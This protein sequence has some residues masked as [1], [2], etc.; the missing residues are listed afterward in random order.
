VLQDQGVSTLR[1]ALRNVA[2]IS[3]AAGEG[4]AQGDNLT[5]RG[6]SARNDIFLDGMR[7]F[8]SYYRDSFDMEE[9]EVLQG[10][11]SMT[12]GRG[13][14]GGVVNQ[15]TKTPEQGHFIGGTLQLGSDLTRARHSFF[16]SLGENFPGGFSIFKNYFAELL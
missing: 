3:L 8:G 12:F 13:S 9:V 14:T 4:G 6:F 7:D 1:D 16:N 11:S 2:G 15:V 10:P 5:I